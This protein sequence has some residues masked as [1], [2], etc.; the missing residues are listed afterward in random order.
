MITLSRK[1]KLILL[2]LFLVGLSVVVIVNFTNICNLQA[3]TFD[4]E[5]VTKFDEKLGLEPT[6]PILNQPLD[7]LGEALLQRKGIVKVDIDYN[8]P[9]RIDIKT[10]RFT[11][12]CFVLDT[13]TGQLRGLS[14]EGRVVAIPDNQT[15][16]EHPTLTNVDAGNLYE[17]CPDERVQILVPQLEKLRDRHTDLYRLITEIDFGSRDELVAT[18]SGLPYKLRMS[19]EGF[20]DQIDDFLYFIERFAPDLDSTKMIDLRFDDMIVKVGGSK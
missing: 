11:P 1:R 14:H 2:S 5:P 17:Y 20:L 16:W 8:L 13:Q 10:N 7:S 15:D 4:G 9:N 6:S 18:I 3:V 12:V 19:A